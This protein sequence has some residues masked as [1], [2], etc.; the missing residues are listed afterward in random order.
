MPAVA[1]PTKLLCVWRPSGEEAA[2]IPVSHLGH[3]DELKQ[4]LHSLLGVPRFRQA[5]VHGDVILDDHARLSGMS[6]VQLVVLPVSDASVE[7]ART[8]LC[9][10][11]WGWQWKVE[12]MVRACHDPNL[13]AD[14]AGELLTPIQA[15]SKEGHR[16]MVSLLLEAGAQDVSDTGKQVAL[17][18]ASMAGHNEVVGLLLEAGGARDWAL[19]S[20]SRAGKVC[21]VRMLLQSGADGLTTRCLRES[22]VVASSKNDEEIVSILLEA[23]ALDT[24]DWGWPKTVAASLLCAYASVD[25][26]TVIVYM[27][28]PLVVVL[29]QT[30]HTSPAI[31]LPWQLLILLMLPRKILRARTSSASL[32]A[33]V[34]QLLVPLTILFRGT[35]LQLPMLVFMIVILL[36]PTKIV[37]LLLASST[38]AAAKLLR[39]H[40]CCR[41]QQA[42]PF[43]AQATLVALQV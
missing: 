5:I 9:A 12:E 18:A 31:L 3:V 4:V 19:E 6:D 11:M 15:A 29:R 22:L 23:G 42:A 17:A 30:P 33:I 1:Q 26:S 13:A 25:R 21:V 2:R 36:F 37:R 40:C 32:A 7:D 43:A 38:A 39:G 24:V 28:L 14:F 35:L 41:R 16:E 8:F 27:A 20:A 10:A 34:C